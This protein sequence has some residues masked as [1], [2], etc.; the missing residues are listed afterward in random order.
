M[1]TRPHFTSVRTVLSGAV[2]ALSLS[3]CAPTL[4]HHGYLAY[5]AKP[6]TDIKVG[7]SKD[8]VVDRLG[9]PSQTSVY[10]PTEWYYIDQVS[11]KMTYK[12]PKVTSRSVTVVD[13]DKSN[14][15]V[16]SV[17]TL[18]LADGRDLKPNPAT[19]PTRGRSLTALEQILGT[20]GR[21]RI[22]NSRD[23]D[24]GNQHRRD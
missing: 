8:S 10:D 13:F 11:M 24:P 22:D 7:D 21:Q 6:A 5:D 15:T 14:D 23:Q 1:I 3:A 17:R 9:Q 12:M 2:L 19:T 20:V 16:K 18:S 4:A